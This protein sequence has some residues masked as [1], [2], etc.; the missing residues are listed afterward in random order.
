MKGE[1]ATKSKHVEKQDIG[2][3]VLEVSIKPNFE[4]VA[5]EIFKFLESET[6]PIITIN[7]GINEF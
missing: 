3:Y 4:G 6:T 5:L 7:I 1:S 2:I